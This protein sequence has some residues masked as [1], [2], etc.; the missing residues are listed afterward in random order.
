MASSA[1]SCGNYLLESGFNEGICEE[2]QIDV[3][4][5]ASLQRGAKLYMNYCFGCHSLKYA[6]FQRVSE[7]LGIPLDLFQENCKK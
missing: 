1:S 4:D 5:K 2:T 3:S 7:D 6:R